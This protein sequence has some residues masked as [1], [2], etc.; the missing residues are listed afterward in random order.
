MCLCVVII[1]C[2]LPLQGGVIINQQQQQTVGK[3]TRNENNRCLAAVVVLL[4]VIAVSLCHSFRISFRKSSFIAL[5][6]HSGSEP[7]HAKLRVC[8]YIMHFIAILFAHFFFFRL[9]LVPLY[10]SC[11]GP[12]KAG[13]SPPHTK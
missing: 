4:V 6:T 5:G 7:T 11:G 13:Q 1:A 12:L 8:V 3:N 9:N 10:D 2:N